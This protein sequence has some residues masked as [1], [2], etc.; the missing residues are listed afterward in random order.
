MRHGWIKDSVYGGILAEAII[1]SP[2]AA[3]LVIVFHV[4]GHRSLQKLHFNPVSFTKTVSTPAVV[5][6]AC[7]TTLAIVS[8]ISSWNSPWS[9][10]Q[11]TQET[12]QAAQ[13]GISTKSTPLLVGHKPWNEE[14]ET[15]WQ[16]GCCST[17]VEY[18]VVRMK[19]VKHQAWNK[20][21]R[22]ASVYY[23]L[24]QMDQSFTR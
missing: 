13:R 23:C 3:V 9:W 19:R 6:I 8:E 2:C 16:G 7:S 20:N 15:G 21:G 17:N 4:V 18:S 10:W 12:L 11:W 5:T 24:Q 1:R 22:R 14:H